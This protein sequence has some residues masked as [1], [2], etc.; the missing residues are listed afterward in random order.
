MIASLIVLETLSDFN[1]I[2]NCW[3]TLKQY[4][5]SVAARCRDTLEAAL[6]DAIDLVTLDQLKN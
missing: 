6:V 2:E 1:P 3:S 4:L 5:R